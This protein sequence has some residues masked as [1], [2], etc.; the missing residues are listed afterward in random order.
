MGR[1]PTR[2]PNGWRDYPN[3]RLRPARPAASRGRVQVLVR[4]CFLIHGPELSATTLY[5]WCRRWQRR[6]DGKRINQRERWSIVRALRVMCDR[7]DRAPTIGRPWCYRI[8]PEF[9]RTWLDDMAE[10][11]K[12]PAT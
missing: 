1:S 9:A 5:E 12:T 4:R 7:L 2:V 8:K 3:L 11:E 10:R 6:H